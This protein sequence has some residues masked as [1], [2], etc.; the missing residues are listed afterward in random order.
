M[1]A[2][3]LDFLILCWAASFTTRFFSFCKSPDELS[4]LV[5][6]IC[7]IIPIYFLQTNTKKE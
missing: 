2:F 6:K 1:G 4:V 5:E 3:V 7:Q